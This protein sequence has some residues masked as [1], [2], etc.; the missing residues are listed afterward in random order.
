MHRKATGIV[1][2]AS[3][4]QLD[5]YL[6]LALTVFTVTQSSA[7]AFIEIRFSYDGSCLSLVRPSL[8]SHLN[9]AAM[10]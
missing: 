10:R 4:Q 9:D 2:N 7:K 8:P 1:C 6:G 3:L 5:G